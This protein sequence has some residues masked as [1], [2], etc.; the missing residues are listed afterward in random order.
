MPTLLTSDELEIQ[1]LFTE[2]APDVI[3][4]VREV[5]EKQQPLVLTTGGD[6]TTYVVNLATVGQLTLVE[7]GSDDPLDEDRVTVLMS[8]AEVRQ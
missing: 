2:P 3:A 5:I 4:F 8:L 6:H 7:H 1:I